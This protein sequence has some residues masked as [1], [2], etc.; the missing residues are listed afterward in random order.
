MIADSSSARRTLFDISIQ[1]A[2]GALRFDRS[3]RRLA[4]SFSGKLK[5]PKFDLGLTIA[6]ASIDTIGEFDINAH[7]T[8][9]LP[10]A[11]DQKLRLTILAARPVHLQF[12]RPN[13]LVLEG[14]VKVEVNGATFEAYAL[15]DDPLYTFGLAAKGV[16]FDLADSI[17]GH[18][19]VLV[20][21]QEYDAT[22]LR[23]LNEYYR[24]LNST[25]ESLR[26]VP[27]LAG[28]TASEPAAGQI[29]LWKSGT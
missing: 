12:R 27:G 18:I 29:F 17:K 5:L 3:E 26:D 10:T 20:A 19:P 8:V 13:K 28:L 1:Q 15:L 4:G 25:F 9:A 11:A 24:H 14:G 21:D 6:N 16:R 2:V 23:V 7:G 22:K